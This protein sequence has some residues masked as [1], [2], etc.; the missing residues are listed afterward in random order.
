MILTAFSVVACTD[1]TENKDKSSFKLNESELQTVIGDENALTFT[2][3]NVDVNNV[4]FT[5]ENPEI[6][7]VNEDGLVES[8]SIGSTNIIATC[9]KFSSTCKVSVSLGN[10]LPQLLIESERDHYRIGKTDGGYPFEVCILYNGKKFYDA[11]IT[12]KSLDENVVYFDANNEGKMLVNSFG[13]T[14]VCFSAKWRGITE[15][16][17]PSLYKVVQVTVIEEVYFYVNNLQL[18]EINLCTVDQFEGLSYVN[19]MAFTPSVSI[20]GEVIDDVTY[21][22]PENI[23]EQSDVGIRAIKQGTGQIVLSY[24]DLTGEEYQAVVTVNVIR[25]EANYN[26]EIKYFSSFTGTMK[27]ETNGYEDITLSKKLFG[28]DNEVGFEAYYEDQKLKTENGKILGLPEDYRGSYLAQLKVQTDRVVYYVDVNVYCIIVQNANDLKNFELKFLEQDNPA[29]AGIDETKVTCINGYCI[30]LNDVDATGV[31]IN[32]E[33]FDVTYP[34]VNG[35]NQTVQAKIE[36]SR[37]DKTVFR[38]NVPYDKTDGLSAFGFLG[39][40][41]GNGHT[42]SNLDTSVAEG[43][44]GGGLFGY[45]L[46]NAVIENVGFLDLNI[47]NSSGIAYESYVPA[48]RPSGKDNNG[49]R[50]DNTFY[51]DIYVKLSTDT[52]NPKGAIL[53]KCFTPMGLIRFENII[54]DGTGVK[55]GTE[56]SGGILMNQGVT[57][58]AEPISTRFSSRDVYVI[59]DQYPACFDGSATVHGFNQANGT[60]LDGQTSGGSSWVIKYEDNVYSSKFAFYSNIEQMIEDNNSYETFTSISWAVTD[61]P[62]FKTAAGVFASLNGEIALDNTISLNSTENARKLSLVT[63]SG[64]T[65]K[66]NQIVCDETQLSVDSDNQIKL[67]N[68][69]GAQTEYSITVKY[70]YRDKDGQMT[71]KVK[72]YPSV[73]VIDEQAE[74]SEFNGELNLSKYV[75]GAKRIVK[76]KQII[77]ENTYNLSVDANGKILDARVQIKQDYSG[78]ENSIFII[79]TVDLTYK[80]TNLAVYSHIING[81][82]D[83]EVL[84]HTQAT[85]KITGYYV[86]G[87]NVDFKEYNNVGHADVFG[88]LTLNKEH[89]FQGVF[90]GRG[91]VITNFRPDDTGLL[92][93]VYSDSQEN[94]GRSV[95]RNVAFINVLSQSQKDFAIFG[96]FIESNGS[97]QTQLENVHVQIANTYLSAFN[98]TSNYKGLFKYNTSTK[99]NS[100]KFKNVYVEIAEEEYVDTVGVA[101]GSI[102]SRDNVGVSANL[103]DRSAR[104][105]NVITVTKMN[106]CVYRQYVGQSLT[107]TFDKQHMYFVYAGNDVGS[108]GLRCNWLEE[109]KMYCHSPVAESA[110]K[111]SYLYENVYRYDSASDIEQERIKALISSN[112]WQIKDG[113]LCWTG[114]AKIIDITNPDMNFDVS[115]KTI[116]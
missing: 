52:V 87:G 33:V 5:S 101:H 4:V 20:A 32:H 19:E 91:H 40:F 2:A 90:D 109:D 16:Q 79:D 57:L 81:A 29:T 110:E 96:R 100:F 23:V 107:Q 89:V 112:Y 48:P 108:L 99:I 84:K 34:Y 49:L 88:S 53:N 94:G 8:I 17:A 6:A 80:F 28:S 97:N 115:I 22:L 50:T 65:A 13:T 41:N 26:K 35:K 15:E 7:T 67:A 92:G 114:A 30:M 64:D 113:E 93:A 1:T 95:I 78:V 85:A 82:Q 54:V 36:T 31:K 58:C 102:F 51:H 116:Y 39:T 68:A 63:L 3:V 103:Q 105:E 14:S 61:Y 86:L 47:S 10:K 76:V 72:A 111:G 37:Y 43:K 46:G 60:A 77:G 38:T 44:T 59:S 75:S 69:V 45:I 12:Y 83:F 18:D 106:P 74:M 66:I 62:M 42:I 11:E 56:K 98:P 73:I 24:T 104:F 27:D 9:G 21:T 55:R 71:I 70:T 25:P